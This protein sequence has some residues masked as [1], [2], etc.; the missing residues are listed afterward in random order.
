MDIVELEKKYGNFYAPVFQIKVNGKDI[1]TLGEDNTKESLEISSVTID[2][3][4]DGADTFSFTVNNAFDLARRELLTFVDEILV[5]DAP[6]EIRFGYGSLLKTLMIGILVTVKISFPSGGAPQVEVGGFDVSHRMMKQMKPRNWNDKKDSEVVK[7]I[8]EEY[9]LQINNTDNDDPFPNQASVE[10]TGVIHPQIVKQEKENDFEFLKRLAERNY[11]EF[12]VFRNTLYFRKPARES[13]PV[14]I[15]EWNKSLVSFS[16]EFDIAER[17][18]EVKVMGQ[19][20]EKKINIEATAKIDNDEIKKMFQRKTEAE[21]QGRTVTNQL[22]SEQVKQPVTSKEHAEHMARAILL[23]KHE[24]I[25][26]GSGESIGIPD[27]LA[28][29]NINLLG[30]GSKFSQKYYLQKTNHS[31]SNSGYKTTFDVNR[32]PDEKQIDVKSETTNLS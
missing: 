18:F 3:T 11:Y 7:V 1:M 30:L 5:F 22:V 10:E 26:K 13:D 32:V 25:L 24:N 4:L 17:V 19:N 16:P 31:I 21:Q 12:F 2:N 15:L 28:G 8:A 23:K 27:I 20:T 29:T 14:V 6:V 9:K